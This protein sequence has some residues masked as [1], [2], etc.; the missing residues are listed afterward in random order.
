MESYVILYGILEGMFGTLAFTFLTSKDKLKPYREAFGWMT[1]AATIDIALDILATMVDESPYIENFSMT[2]DLLMLPFFVFEGG[3][4]IYQDTTII[5][6]RKRWIRLLKD[7]IPFLLLIALSTSLDHDWLVALCLLYGVLYISHYYSLFARRLYRHRKEL[8]KNKKYKEADSISW[9]FKVIALNIF[10]WVLY[11][12][13]SMVGFEMMFFAYT[14]VSIYIWLYH[15]HHLNRQVKID[16]KNLIASATV[17]PIEIVDI[18]NTKDIRTQED[19]RKVLKQKKTTNDTLELF[20]LDFP[21]F[22]KNLQDCAT[23]KI[24][25]KD[26]ILAMFICQGKKNEELADILCIGVKSVEV[27]RSR[28]RTK[29]NL[30]KNDTLKKFLLEKLN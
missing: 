13:S 15:A 7:E 19:Q 17:A 12:V 14:L 26:L 21:R 25:Q 24:T 28:L 29:L 10:L 30:S 23:A 11:S 18:G 4:L 5:P 6:W 27:A 2:K 20:L 3:T 16:I 8:I 1:L 22:R 9:I